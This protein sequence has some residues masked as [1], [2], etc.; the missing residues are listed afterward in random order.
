MSATAPEKV[1]EKR[2]RI[3]V[4]YTC[5]RCGHSR[6][7]VLDLRR[8][9]LEHTHSGRIYWKFPCGTV[10]PGEVTVQQALRA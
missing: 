3:N 8:H 4:K 1:P 9:G 5:R 6:W 7:A 10:E 2:R